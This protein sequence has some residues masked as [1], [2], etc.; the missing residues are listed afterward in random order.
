MNYKPVSFDQSFQE[1][2]EDS[3]VSC[4]CKRGM[5]TLNPFGHEAACSVTLAATHWRQGSLQR[6]T[7]IFPA[8]DVQSAPIEA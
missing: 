5:G 1:W 4:S 8:A 7:G 3:K 6:Y 2:A